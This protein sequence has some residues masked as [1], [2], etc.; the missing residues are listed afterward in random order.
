[1]TR[2]RDL[3]RREPRR[4]LALP[5]WLERLLAVG[6]VTADPQ[7]ARRQRSANVAA[8]AMAANGAGHLVINAAYDFEG[9][10]IIHAYNAFITVAAL[11]A[12]RLHRLGDH[13]AAF[14]L[15]AIVLCGTIFVVSALGTASD[16]H[17]YLTLAG[18]MLFLFGVHN[19]RMFLGF[20][21]VFI[22]VLLLILNFAPVDGFILPQ[23]VQLRAMLSRQ[24][25]INTIIIN[26][27]MILYALTAL[28]N[29][30]AELEQQYERSE[31]L[32]TTVMPASIAARLKSG[33]EDRIADRI[34]NLSVLF[35]D[36]VG[37]TSAAHELPPEAVVDYLD[38]LVRGFD[39]LADRHGIEKIKTIGDCYMAAAGFDGRAQ[40]GAVAIGRFALALL[41]ETE[42]T[43]P[44]GTR[45]L[46]L[47]IGIHC[48]PATAGV[49]GDV[50]F[51]YDVWGHAVNVASRMESHGEPGRVQVSE[52]FRD[53]A[54]DVFVYQER[55]TTEIKGIGEARTYFLIRL[56]EV[57]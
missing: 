57:S 14:A 17:I 29:A 27:A 47:R 41:E 55:G 21:A 8:Y 54:G 3:V 9:L 34:E 2:L 30:E 39:A 19:W 46:T 36:L 56:C 49:I 50:R 4:A 18:A 45:R 42:Q 31:A 35:A 52:D 1:M 12:P 10:L 5:A 48:G 33:A 44:L 32:V 15:I 25:M 20:F 11:L 26:A 53:L 23:D 28:R 37:F 22:A 7:L 51:S 43:M 40:E 38:A 16:L 24:A 13:A 6:I